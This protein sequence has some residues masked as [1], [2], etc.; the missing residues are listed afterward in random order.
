MAINLKSEADKA[1]AHP[2]RRFGQRE[3]KLLESVAAAIPFQT[4]TAGTFNTV[5]GDAS[6]TIPV[7][8][9]KT[10]DIVLVSVKT[11]GAVPV[12]V[13]AAAAAN[14]SIAVTMSA[15]PAADH[16]LQYIVV[17]ALA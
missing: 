13:V 11:A 12:S 10:G 6:E 8:S 4:V 16:V 9:A 3:R 2:S 14:G 7:A 17:R 15:N 5:G 1:G